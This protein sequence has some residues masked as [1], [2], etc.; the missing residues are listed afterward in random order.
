MKN[1]HLFFV[2]LFF[3]YFNSFGQT[4][5]DDLRIQ[6]H[7][8]RFSIS[9]DRVDFNGIP[10][11]IDT[12]NIVVNYRSSEILE[13]G[14]K[15]RIVNI[16]SDGNYVIQVLPF[17][18][19]NTRVITL[20][21][22]FNNRN[23]ENNYFL[24]TPQ[25]YESFAEVSKRRGRFVVNTSSTLIKIRPGNGKDTDDDEV[26]F[27]ELGNDFNVGLTAGWRLTNYS[28]TGSVSLVG[29]FGYSAIK[30]TPQTTRDFISSE[31]SQSA[32]TFNAGLIFEYNKFQLSIFT[33][34]D[35][36]SGEI[37]RNWIYRDRP[38]IGIGFGYEI[39]KPDGRN[40]N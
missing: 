16:I 13:N 1:Y 19:S 2:V 22:R 18:G 5:T 32:V 3:Y 26:I 9:L 4:V 31:S 34:I 10:I 29:G 20:N 35:V 15:F 39:F 8:L 36:M 25:Q 14:W 38:W 23:G 21:S 7:I 37:G 11:T 17:K 30:V 40:E 27:S 24:M 6:T 33:G 12:S 28:K